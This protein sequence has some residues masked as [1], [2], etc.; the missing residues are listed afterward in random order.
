[1]FSPDKL[2]SPIFILGRYEIF[3]QYEKF[4]NL[5]QVFV[6]SFVD[7]ESIHLLG[8]FKLDRNC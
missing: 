8:K 2:N 6:L 3:Q 1:M 7:S 5:Y 4:S